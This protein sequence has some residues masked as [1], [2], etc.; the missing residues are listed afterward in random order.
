M[1]AADSE[2]YQLTASMAPLPILLL[3]KCQ[4]SMKSRIVRTISVFVELAFAYSTC[5]TATLCAECFV[6][7]SIRWW[8]ERCTCQVAA[9]CPVSSVEIYLGHPEGIELN[10]GELTG[11]NRHSDRLSA[12]SRWKKRFVPCRAYEEIL[13]QSKQ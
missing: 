10:T 6:G 2:L 7:H 13:R 4:R 1:I 12:A 3:C 9:V 11:D 8:D 5:L